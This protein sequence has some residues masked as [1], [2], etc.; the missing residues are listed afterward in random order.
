METKAFVGGDGRASE[1]QKIVLVPISIFQIKVVIR[2]LCTSLGCYLG[3]K[4]L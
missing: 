3:L 4:L 1:G 2:C